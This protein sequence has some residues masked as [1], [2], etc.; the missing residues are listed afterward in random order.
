RNPITWVGGPDVS[1][2]RCRKSCVVGLW[3]THRLSWVVTFTLAHAFLGSIQS[4]VRGGRRGRRRSSRP[5]KSQRRPARACGLTRRW[6]PTPEEGAAHRH[7]ISAPT[8]R[9]VHS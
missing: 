3:P 8:R 9:P 7:A 2:G 6:R 1:G 4:G 5:C